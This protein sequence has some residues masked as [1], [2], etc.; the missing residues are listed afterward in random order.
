VLE[1]DYD[2]DYRYAGRPLPDRAGVAYKPATAR[3]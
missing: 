1:D 3:V 2:A